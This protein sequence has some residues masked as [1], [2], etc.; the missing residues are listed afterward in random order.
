MGNKEF[1]D[2]IGRIE[3]KLKLCRSGLQK[4]KL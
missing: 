3:K 1:W 2:S 4:L